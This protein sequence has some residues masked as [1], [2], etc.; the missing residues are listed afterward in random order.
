[1]ATIASLALIIILSI[2][3]ISAVVWLFAQPLLDAKEN[4]QARSNLPAPTS[5]ASY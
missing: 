3:E 2:I 5:R 1:M 4:W